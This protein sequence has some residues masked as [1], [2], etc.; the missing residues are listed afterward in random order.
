MIAPDG[1]TERAVALRD[2]LVAAGKLISPEWQAAVLA[3]PRH[4]FVPEFYE[5]GSDPTQWKLVSASSSET[6][7]HWWNQVWANTSLVTQ[8][9]DSGRWGHQ[10]VTAPTSSSSAPSLMTR[11]LEALDIR[12]GHRVLEIGTGTGY[13]AALMSHRFGAENI[14]SVEVDTGLVNSARSRLA[15]LGYHPTLAAVDGVAG[16]PEHAPYDRIMATC[17]VSR[18]PWSWAE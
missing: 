4:E 16:L 18:V 3:V 5:R 14:F 11:M 9:G 12:D 15:A 8:L 1:W 6:R 2:E 13:N 7:E 17:A 10:T